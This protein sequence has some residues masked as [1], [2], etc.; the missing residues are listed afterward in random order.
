MMAA[1]EALG[2]SHVISLW[3]FYGG[4]AIFCLTIAIVFILSTHERRGT[5]LR[6]WPI[7]LMVLGLVIFGSGLVWYI[8]PPAGPA[9]SPASIE[10]AI[11]DLAAYHSNDQIGIVNLVLFIDL[12]SSQEEAK[13]NNFTL[14]INLDDGESFKATALPI[15]ESRVFR[16]PDSTIDITP[17]TTLWGRDGAPIIRGFRSGRLWF[18]FDSFA[19][20]AGLAHKD[21]KLSLT[22]TDAH[23]AS[24]TSTIRVGEIHGPRKVTVSPSI[25]P[26]DAPPPFP[27]PPA[28]PPKT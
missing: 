14:T 21:T 20:F 27:T 6:M 7:S 3:L 4:M 18:A 28:S 1:P 15:L 13:I 5:T 23:G 17:D 24:Y 11:T 26:P 12:R 2:L 9:V 22:V 8:R 25:N 10:A 19:N 16:G